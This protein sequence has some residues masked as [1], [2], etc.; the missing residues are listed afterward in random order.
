M[1]LLESN[2]CEKLRSR[3]W[4]IVSSSRP[5]VSSPSWDRLTVRDDSTASRFSPEL[6][7]ALKRSCFS[8]QGFI[9]T[10]HDCI[11]PYP[12]NMIK[13]IS[14][15]L[16]VLHPLIWTGDILMFVVVVDFCDFRDNL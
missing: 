4:P 8:F 7:H 11:S 1:L 13:H 5:R 6:T 3:I 14:H 16:L 12:I 9:L 2:H 15:V 10:I